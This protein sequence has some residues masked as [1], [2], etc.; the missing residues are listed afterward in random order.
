MVK[1]NINSHTLKIE[2]QNAA[3]MIDGF[4]SYGEHKYVTIYT[5]HQRAISLQ[6]DFK[7]V[8]KLLTPFR[9]KPRLNYPLSLWGKHLDVR[10]YDHRNWGHR[11][12]LKYVAML[13][14]IFHIENDASIWKVLCTNGLFDIWNWEAPFSSLEDK[15]D[16]SILLLRIYEADHD[17]SGEVQYGP[18]T[19]WDIIPAREVNLV[20]KII[21]NAGFER[22]RDTVRK[23]LT[24]R[25]RLIHEERVNDTNALL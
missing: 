8:S 15:D 13:D 25:G 20:R 11:R 2:K 18:S 5:A 23:V 7:H 12:P 17:F 9:D 6:N 3:A 21:P 24:T 1:I 4:V 10:P 19:R 22:T 14:E 16:P